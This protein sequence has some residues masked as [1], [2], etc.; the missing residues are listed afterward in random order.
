MKINKTLEVMH[1]M[2]DHKIPINESNSE[3]IVGIIFVSKSC[4]TFQYIV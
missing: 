3:A 1:D 4:Y 2:V